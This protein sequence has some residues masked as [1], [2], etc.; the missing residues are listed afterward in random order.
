M[1]SASQ[2]QSKNQSAAMKAI[3]LKDRVLEAWLAS[4]AAVAALFWKPLPHEYVMVGLAFVVLAAT[5]LVRFAAKHTIALGITIAAMYFLSCSAADGWR[6]PAITA[7]RTTQYMFIMVLT[8]FATA[9]TASNVTYRLRERQA[10]QE[11]IRTAEALTGAQLR[12]QLAETAISIGK[13]AAALSH[14]INSPLGVLRSGIETLAAIEKSPEKFERMA[15]TRL[16]LYGSVLESAGR[17]EEVTHRLRRFVNLEEAE[18][19]AADLNEL[20]S[21]VT[22]MYEK[23]IAQRKIQ[24]NLDLERSLPALSCRP[25][26]L[27]TAFSSMLSNAIQAVNGNGCVDISTR[28]RELEVEVTIRDNGRGMTPQEADTMFEPQFKVAGSRVASGNW[29]H[30]GMIS[31]ETTPGAGTAVHV[32]LPVAA[33]GAA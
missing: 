22:L 28:L 17:I 8:A 13:L 12:A 2:L 19:K 20:L 30:G 4:V 31:V 1:A 29:S 3:H 9:I 23:D 16:A 21:A 24:L 32:V 18:L 15:E 10:A 11:A 6:P 14:E 27:T 5:A 7:H 25:Q 26:L 33:E